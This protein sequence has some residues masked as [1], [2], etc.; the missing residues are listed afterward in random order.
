MKF[1]YGALFVYSGAFTALGIYS[2]VLASQVKSDPTT[3]NSRW[4]QLSL[5]SRLFYFKNSQTVLVD[6]YFSKMLT[7]GI[8]YLSTGAIS[9]V[10]GFFLWNYNDFIDDNWRPKLKSKLHEDQMIR[11]IEVIIVIKKQFKHKYSPDPQDNLENNINEDRKPLIEEHQ[12]VVDRN[13]EGLDNQGIDMR[14]GNITNI[15]NFSLER[16]E[17]HKNENVESQQFHRDETEAKLRESQNQNQPIPNEENKDKNNNILGEGDKKKKKLIRRKK[18]ED[19][20]IHEE[21]D[22]NHDN[23]PKKIFF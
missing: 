9:I 10:N 8:L 23:Q 2:C 18:K 6:A 20:E 16:R 1:L 4:S 14:L 19:G 7:V 13:L 22:E 15:Y 21:N 5:N 12:N 17:E 11:L 3:F